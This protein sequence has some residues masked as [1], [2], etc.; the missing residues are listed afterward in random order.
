MKNYILLSLLVL[1]LFQLSCRYDLPL[2]E[3]PREIEEPKEPSEP[4]DSL[5]GNPVDSLP[6]N[7]IDSLP[8]LPPDPQPISNKIRVILDT[9]ANNELDDQ[10]AIAYLLFNGNTFTVEGITVNATWNGGGLQ[11]HFNEA[12]RV[13]ELCNLY[14]KIPLLK[15]ASSNFTSIKG[16]LANGGYD[17]EEA[18]DFIIKTSKESTDRKLVILAVGKLTNVALALQKDP[19]LKNRIKVVWLGSNYP[20]RGEYNME[21]DIPSMNYVLDNEVEFEMVTVRND[22]DSGTDAVRV[23]KEEILKEMPGKGPYISNAVA[24]RHGG[25]F[26][27]FGDYSINL[28]DQIILYGNPPSRALFD[29]AA[30]AI[31]KNPTWAT[32]TKIPAPEFKHG[33]W[34]DRPNN[35]RK[36]IVWEYFDRDA[37]INDF[38]DT[39]ENYVLVEATN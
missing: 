9:D 3:R 20:L 22:K 38:F 19:S 25:S 17:G 28:Y 36:I 4:I 23:S 6:G 30:V 13:M 1:A 7:P 33:A 5:P 11:R 32:A 34:A 2:P 24:G 14:G 26:H 12:V 15:G 16:N 10:H 35:Q 29:M 27:T 18:V 8:E 21:N 31:V 37:I 39:M